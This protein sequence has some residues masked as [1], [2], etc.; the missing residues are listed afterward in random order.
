MAERVL[1]RVAVVSPGTSTPITSVKVG[2]EF[3]LVLYTQDLR[4]NPNGDRIRGVFAAYTDVLY[5]KL[6]ASVRT[7][8]TQTLSFPQSLPLVGNVTLKVFGI[9][10]GPIPYNNSNALT[11]ANT[12][13]SIANL[14]NSR[15]GAGKFTVNVAYAPTS[16]NYVVKFAGYPDVDEQTITASPPQVVVTETLKG[17][18]AAAFFNSFQ[19]SSD[20]PNGKLANNQIDRIDA[21]GAFSGSF[22]GLSTNPY[23]VVRVRMVARVS[24]TTSFT[25]SVADMEYP[26]QLTLVYANLV[27]AD[28]PNET[29]SEVAASD[30]VVQGV[31][32]T[33][34]P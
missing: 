7:Y 12:A 19:Y 2:Q 29:N 23:E 24:G 11:K 14:L 15:F 17:N 18:S 4:P 33:I 32:L 31:D 25:P 6:Y 30:I 3:D 20:Y 10:F 22:T 26:Q 1:H 21:L 8:E 13:K 16:Y 34:T 28:D 27:I 9:L 5:D